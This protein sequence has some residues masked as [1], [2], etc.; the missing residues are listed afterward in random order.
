MVDSHCHLAGPEF[1]DDL[2]AVVER[3]RSAG[4]AQAL[5][6]LAA[7]DEPEIQQAANVSADWSAVRFWNAKASAFGRVYTAYGFVY[8]QA[9]A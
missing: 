5:V 7:D 9:A 4:L 6:I 8:R 3:A 1:A 2:G